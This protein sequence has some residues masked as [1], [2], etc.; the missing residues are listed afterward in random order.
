MSKIINCKICG[1]EFYEKSNKAYCF[2]PECKV[3]A[4]QLNAL[5]SRL[6]SQ[7]NNQLIKK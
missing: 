1:D 5:R 6:K 7:I 4:R 2:N 3:R